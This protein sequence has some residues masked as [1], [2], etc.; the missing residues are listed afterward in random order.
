MDD[1]LCSDSHNDTITRLNDF[2][3]TKSSVVL[4]AVIVIALFFPIIIQS[5]YY[6]RVAISVITYSMLALGLN[7]VLGYAGMLHFGQAAM[8]AIGAYTTALL[9]VKCHISFPLAFLASMFFP[10]LAS[11]IVGF[12]SLRIRGPYLAL[13]TFAFNE[14]VRIV[15]NSWVGLTG[16]PM[17]IP[18]VP[19]PKL[20]SLELTSNVGF[21]YFGLVMLL[22]IYFGCRRVANSHYGRAFLAIREDEVAA[23]SLG[24][25]IAKYKISAFLLS[26]IPAGMAGSYYASYLS[27]VGPTSFTGDTSILIAEMVIIGGRASLP[28]SILGAG[29]LVVALEALRAIADYRNAFIGITLILTLIY[30]PQG[31]LGKWGAA[32]ASMLDFQGKKGKRDKD[33]PGFENSQIKHETEPVIEVL[34]TLNEKTPNVIMC[35][36]SVTKTFGGVKALQ[37]LDFELREG[38]I[39][40]LIGPNGSGKTTLFNAITGIFSPTS[41]EVFY[42]DESITGLCPSKIASKGIQRTFQNVRL[43][44]RLTAGANIRIGGH[45]TVHT[46]LGSVLAR[47]KDLIEKEN[48]ANEDARNCLDFVGLGHRSFEEA[49]SLPY[50]EQKLLEMARAL[51]ANPKVLLLDEPAAGL[52]PTE[53]VSLAK[54]IRNIRKQGVTLF[55][56]EHNMR[57]MMNV[58]DRIIVINFG[59]KVAEGTPCEIQKDPAVQ[60][61]YLGTAQ[62]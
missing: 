35:G 56:V 21:Y 18:G 26:A 33:I 27:F 48:K 22:I 51:A 4:V 57:F 46:G 42:S 17:G 20:G 8:F 40:G 58:C 34:P 52:N 47:S 9:T 28:G 13:I 5:Q 32:A 31:I 55:V 54:V 24:I 15:A 36:K 49:C 6:V 23:D 10:V 43:F 44:Q 16:G 25:N 1:R 41:G 39:L 14:I 62:E 60:E 2:M 3:Q 59:K 11:F 37:S 61:A 30:R 38:E 7:L 19:P 29:I 45:L 53:V 12:P 50:G